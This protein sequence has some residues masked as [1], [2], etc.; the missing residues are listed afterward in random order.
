MSKYVS[1][2]RMSDIYDTPMKYMKEVARIEGWQID[3]QDREL[4]IGFLRSMRARGMGYVTLLKY[5]QSM[6]TFIKAYHKPFRE[7][8]RIDLEDFLIYMERFKPK[9]RKIKW[10]AVKKFFDHI[11]VEGAFFKVRFN[12]RRKRLPEQILTKD[13]VEGLIDNMRGDRNACFCAILYESG[14]RI[15]EILM[16]RRNEVSFDENGAVILVSGKT[17]HRRVRVV[18]YAPLLKRH[19]LKSCKHDDSRIFDISYPNATKILREAAWRADIRKP[20]NPHA[21]RHARATHL[22]NF[23]TESQLKEFFGWRQGSEMAQ[24]Y[25]HLSGRDIDEAILNIYQNDE[26]FDTKKRM[27]IG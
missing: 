14:C 21:F 16:V 20:V 12:I 15:G 25:V 4:F 13:D 18:R 2:E 7:L 11:G 10:Y 1:G 6:S 22:A 23:L 8:A 24:I 26:S 9:T 3:E 17:G 27:G 5:V 19:V